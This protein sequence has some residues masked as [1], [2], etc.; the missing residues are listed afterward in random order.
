M[1]LQLGQGWGQVDNQS[2]EIGV[3]LPEWSEDEMAARPI[4]Y[5]E[6]I[7]FTKLHLDFS[8]ENLGTMM[9]ITM[10]FYGMV[11]PAR[12]RTNIPIRSDCDFISVLAKSKSEIAEV[13][14]SNEKVTNFVKIAEVVEKLLTSPPR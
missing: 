3:I 10:Q 12:K 2:Q 1:F 13:V 8:Q 6:N 7:R 5:L 11:D 14:D 4:E 9:V